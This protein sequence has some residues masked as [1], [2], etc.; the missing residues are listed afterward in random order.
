MPDAIIPRQVSSEGAEAVRPRIDEPVPDLCRAAADEAADSQG[1]HQQISQELWENAGRLRGLISWGGYREPDLSVLDNDTQMRYYQARSKPGFS[2]ER[3]EPWPLLR[4]CY[5][6]A[7]L[8]FHRRES[9]Q[10]EPVAELPSPN[11][12]AADPVVDRI[13]EREAIKVFLE[14][15]VPDPSE[16]E[17]YLLTHMEGKRRGEIAEELGVDRGTV[18]ARLNRAEERLRSLPP[19]E[20][21]FLR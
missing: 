21:D 1:L 2:F 12:D 14:K 6:Y 13:I 16:R 15:H 3:D 18:T 19:D 5:R 20:L 11:G 4:A 7:R 9:Q 10:P 8:D 17:I